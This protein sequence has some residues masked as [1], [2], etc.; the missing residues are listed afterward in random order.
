MYL[1]RLDLTPAN[2]FSL[3]I[4]YL[5]YIPPLRIDTFFAPYPIFLLFLLVLFLTIQYSPH[6]IYYMYRPSHFMW[7]AGFLLYGIL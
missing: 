6:I 5:F 1:F 4:F 7:K 2:T 3:G